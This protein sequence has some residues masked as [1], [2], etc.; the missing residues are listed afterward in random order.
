MNDNVISATAQAR[1]LSEGACPLTAGFARAVLAETPTPLQYLPR[2]TAHIGGPNIYIKRDDN[3]GFALG[4][5]KV[6]QMEYVFGDI[7]GKDVDTVLTT[8]AVQSNHLRVVAAACAKFGLRCD[9]QRENR[10]QTSDPGY[11]ET[12][13]A[14]LQKLFGASVHE[15]PV[16]ED[17]E[18]A[19]AALEVR[20]AEFRAAGQ[21]PYVLGMGPKNP[22]LGALGYVDAAHE[23]LAQADASG[24][25]IDTVVLPSGSAATHAGMLAGLKALGHPAR[26]IGICVRRHRA[27][28]EERVLQR[29]R[30]TA[31]L[32]GADGAVSQADVYIRDEFLGGGYGQATD[33][34]K[35]AVSALAT[36]EGIVLDPVYSGKAMAGLM[37][38]ARDGTF[39]PADNVVFVHTGGVPALFAY[40][41]YFT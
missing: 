1:R 37:S 2:L 32:I 34:M 3:T 6:R 12:G 11:A 40:R 21:R 10:V 36:T 19:D 38:M 20:A 13:N 14:F 22:H 5:N 16:G 33:G 8:S 24:L 18:A 25:D 7:L 30:E 28:Q 9:I 26:V 35:E 17:E 27:A 39:D 29:A 23:L 31:R 15:F 41:S 4:G